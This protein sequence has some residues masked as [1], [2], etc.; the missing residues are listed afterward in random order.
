MYL[1]GQMEFS[2]LF[3]WMRLQKS[4]SNS[5]LFS[6]MLLLP[7]TAF[8]LHVPLLLFLPPSPS[9]SHVKLT[10]VIMVCSSQRGAAVRVSV[11]VC[12]VGYVKVLLTQCP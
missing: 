3:V 10:L 2:V 5:S 11:I 1:V 7:H 12:A 9:L 6:S 4:S 8:I